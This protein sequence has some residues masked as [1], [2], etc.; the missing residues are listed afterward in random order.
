MTHLT[1]LRAS[2]PAANALPVA[3]MITWCLPSAT[4]SYKLRHKNAKLVGKDEF[5]REEQIYLALIG[6]CEHV[7]KSEWLLG[8]SI[9]LHTRRPGL[10][11]GCSGQRQSGDSRTPICGSVAAL[12]DQLMRW[13]S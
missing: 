9:C 6:S 4:V 5:Q 11:Q 3:A 2:R 1:H 8:H 13:L 7:F 12:P 10:G